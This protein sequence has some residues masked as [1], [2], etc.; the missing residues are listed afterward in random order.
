MSTPN[1]STPNP[2][3]DRTKLRDARRIVVKIGSSSLTNGQG[4]VSVEAI[5][6]LT[7]VVG[8]LYH[9]GTQVVLVSS[10]AIAAGFRPL[11]LDKRPKDLATQQAA[12]A[13]GQSRLMA[14]Y[15]ES[16]W[17]HSISVAQV[18]LTAEDLMR[19]TQY[20]NAFRSLNRLLN[21]GVLP[22][23]NEND[24][25]A[26]HEIRFG[27]NDRLA[28][29]VAAVTKADVLFMLSDVD[30]LYDGPPTQPGAR[31]IANVS[32]EA[33]LAHISVGDSG[34]SVGTGGMITK[35]Q[36]A[37]IA[38]DAGIPT[39]L[40]S[41]ENAQAAIDGED[42][43]T[44]FASRGERKSARNAWLEHMAISRGSIMIDDGAVEAITVRRRSLL[45]AGL[46]GVAGTFEAGDVVEI[47]NGQGT[48]VAR[49]L[50]NYSVTELPAMV[51][52]STQQLRDELGP[53]YDRVV[54][55]TDDTVIVK[56]TTL[57]S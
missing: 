1:L 25:V 21:L 54:V 43:G 46:I 49:G 12:A 9:G 31:R 32:A 33:N 51:G 10:G 41:A 38:T 36:A 29:L 24:A 45:P 28:A 19:R 37:S 4:G 15:T 5:D 40:T 53:E 11:G 39:F 14:Q 48:V 26:T 35:L 55:H 3:L 22:V 20:N 2:V 56:Q 16:F 18:L 42:V 23:V 34:S 47:T 50:T 52:K 8:Q 57:T 44:W 27:D 30:A 6:A 7:R 17:K 13:V